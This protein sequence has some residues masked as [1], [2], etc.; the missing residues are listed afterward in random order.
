MISKLKKYIQSIEN[1]EGASSQK[2][3]NNKKR[4]Q[5]IKVQ[6]YPAYN[7]QNQFVKYYQ[8]SKLK[9]N[10]IMRNIIVIRTIQN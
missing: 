1:N 8:D 6:Q 9:P 7:Y 10:K 3:H 2:Q 5:N 4:R